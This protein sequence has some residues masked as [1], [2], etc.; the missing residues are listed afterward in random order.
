MSKPGCRHRLAQGHPVAVDALAE[1]GDVL[2]GERAAAEERRVEA[3]TLLVHE[4]DDPERPPRL[5]P[6][7]PQQPDRVHGRDDAEC[8]VE[9]AA[10]RHGVQVRADEDRPAAACLPAPD[11]VAGRVDL[12]LEPELAS[13]ASAHR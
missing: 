3:R 5:E 7:L 12:D 1:V 9:A 10:G 8:A 4:R 6:L 11:Q 2:S 13:C